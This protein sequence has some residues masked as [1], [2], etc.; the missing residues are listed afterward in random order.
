MTAILAAVL[1]AS[2][3]CRDSTRPD[4]VPAK[5]LL[6]PASA[7]LVA[8]ATTQLSV[9]I[10]TASGAVLADLVPTYTTDNSAVATVSPT[11]LVT[12]VGP[13]G[14]ANITASYKELNSS[15]ASIAVTAGPAHSIAKATDLPVLPDAGSANP[16]SV[17]VTDAY[18]NGIAGVN[19]TFAVASGGGSVTPSAALTDASGVA[20]TTFT[21]GTRIDAN[22]V[23]ATAAGLFGSPVLFSA[24]SAAGPAQGIVKVGPDPEVVF[25]GASFLD[26]VRVQVTDAY[27]NPKSGATVAFAVTAGGGTISP[28]TTTTD[29]GGRAAAKFVLGTALDLVNSA[30]ATLSGQSSVSFSTRSILPW[31][32]VESGT[33]NSL[34][35]VWGTSGSNV[36]AVGAGGTILHWDGTSWSR[37][38]SGTT[39]SLNGIWGTSATDVWAVGQG[40][41]T[42]HYDGVSW[43]AV[44]SAPISLFSVWNTSPSDVWATGN[45][46][47]PIHYDGTTWQSANPQAFGSPFAIWGASAHDIW[48]VRTLSSDGYVYHGD[49]SGWAR[50]AFFSNTRLNAIWGSSA[51]DIWAV[52]SRLAHYDGV[53]WSLSPVTAAQ[54]GFNAI[55]GSSASNVWAVGNGGK[56]LHYEGATWVPLSS[57]VTETLTGVWVNS[58][59]DAWAVGANGVILH[60]RSN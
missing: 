58:R 17:K 40:G 6:S 18:G 22:S 45:Y 13:A 31:S 35:G 19:V 43:A 26:S 42:L 38:S 30:T 29:A 23:S 36:W 39:M 33:T 50:A 1:T 21:L 60:G 55:S 49:I 16:V 14:T 46:P 20:A 52:G 48:A 2:P 34:T 41:T 56:L 25:A 44:Q 53:R 9:L 51:S 11:G 7:S 27:G 54:I 4:T 47:T 24:T 10:L 37:V 32:R 15:P 28:G 57:G 8:G 5:V 59:T 3:S 12:A